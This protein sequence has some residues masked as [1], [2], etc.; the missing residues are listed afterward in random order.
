MSAASERRKARKAYAAGEEQ[1]RDARLGDDVAR[2]DG[3]QSG[4]AR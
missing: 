4:G 2:R 1:R 3:A